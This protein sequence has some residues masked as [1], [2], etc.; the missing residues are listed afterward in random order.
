MRKLFI[1]LIVG[2]VSIPAFAQWRRAA[3][4]GADVRALIAD[5]RDPDTLYLG[6]SGGQVYVSHDGAKSWSSPRIGIPFPRYIVD[7]LVLDRQGRLWAACW[8]LWG[9]GVVAVSDDGGSTWMRRDAGLEELSVRAIA[10]DPHDANFVVVAGLTGVFRSTDAGRT[11][12]KISDQENVESLAI[13]PRTHDRIYVG[14]RRQGIRTDDGGKSWKLINNGMVL[15][16]DMFSITIEPDNPDSVWVSTCGWVYHSPNTG[17]NWTRFRDGFNNRRIHDIE[18]DPCD[19]SSLYAGSVAG[20]YRSHD[21]GKT[22]YVV[23]DESLVV[24]KVLLH[25][26]RPGR[27]IVGVEGD[28]IYVSNDNA[29][30]FTRSCEGLH[31]LRITSIAPD[32]T[33]KDRVYATVA[34]GGAASGVYE[35]DDDGATWK[36][37]SAA[38]L[39][40]VL[41]LSIAEEADGGPKFVAGTEKGFFWSDDGVDWTQSAPTYAPI[42]VDKVLRL[43]RTR[44]FSATSEG[45]LTSRDSGKSWYRLAGSD[46]RT[47]DIALGYL[48]DKRA[49]FALTTVGVM[50]FDGE[51]WK[52]IEAAPAKGRTLAIRSVSGTQLLFVAGSGGVKAGRIDVDGT[53]HESD[54]PDAQYAA[55]FGASRSSDPL[56]FLTSRQQ[57]EILVGEP[58]EAEWMSLS[59]PS[60]TAEVTA[61][62]P[63][64][65]D[66]KRFYVGTLGEGVYVFEGKTQK[67]VARKPDSDSASLANGNSSR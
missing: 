36:K 65:F 38:T 26:Q 52:A 33:A 62:S 11:W 22:W 60:R 67:Y 30:S 40:E 15:D 25:S 39:P 20:L 29:K 50:V 3:L 61:I 59:V 28:G 4:Y 49:L 42:R 45:V 64:P 23:S 44:Y 6:T 21:H 13:D 7:N 56:L 24:N 58:K 2:F 32:P 57:R 48:G 37:I 12:T 46:N 19:K 47:A 14:T 9:G 51:R 55:V 43:N 27:V 17:D 53:W 35:S 34:F 5:P 16:T 18:V 1:F 66:V 41:S 10:L 31:N 63:D 54:A 8:G